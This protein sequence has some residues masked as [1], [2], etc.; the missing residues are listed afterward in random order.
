MA[1]PGIHVAQAIILNATVMGS[2]TIELDEEALNNKEPF[3]YSTTMGSSIIDMT[4]ICPSGDQPKTKHT[5]IIDTVMGKTSLKLNKNC[6]F[7]VHSQGSLSNV[8]LPDGSTMTSGSRTFCSRP[9]IST[10]D[11]EIHAH[12]VLG[13][14]DIILV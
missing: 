13:T 14:L 10:L 12:T 9:E 4:R 3:E 5:I 2:S 7:C 11:L 8:T 1:K 6:A